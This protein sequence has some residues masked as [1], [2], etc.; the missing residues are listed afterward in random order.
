MRHDEELDAEESRVVLD[1]LD[2]NL[3]LA[4]RMRSLE[5]V[6]RIGHF[7]HQGLDPSIE[8]KLQNAAVLCRADVFALDQL[9]IMSDAR[10]QEDVRQTRVDPAGGAELRAR[11]LLALQQRIAYYE[12]RAQHRLPLLA[13]FAL[14]RDLEVL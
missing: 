3:G 2:D 6:A 5:L 11:G 14:N 12:G 1:I 7:R 10:K 9:Q 13:H 4:Q 8:F